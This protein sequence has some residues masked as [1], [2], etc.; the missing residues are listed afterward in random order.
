AKH[1]YLWDHGLLNNKYYKS[2]NYILE[3]KEIMSLVKKTYRFY[4]GTYSDG[5]FLL[6]KKFRGL[7]NGDKSYYNFIHSEN[8]T[9]DKIDINVIEKLCCLY[10]IVLNEIDIELN[11]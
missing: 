3:N 10:K 2:F 4:I 9:I 6:N 11:K 7:G 1:V 5:L 8:D